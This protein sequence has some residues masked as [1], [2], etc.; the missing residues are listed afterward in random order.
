MN[1]F[2]ERMARIMERSRQILMARKKMRRR[3]AAICV[4]LLI[5]CTAI[6]LFPKNQGAFE[7]E[8]PHNT[9]VGTASNSYVLMFE[10]VDGSTTVT[11]HDMVA[12]FLE[13]LGGI[14]ASFRPDTVPPG[15][16]SVAQEDMATGSSGAKETLTII[17][18]D[19]AGNQKVYT[20]TDNI[21]KCQES[22]QTVSLTKEQIEAI[23][24]YIL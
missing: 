14:Y 15:D 18:T 23:R 7:Q 24:R 9:D 11:D 6:L 21:L 8:Q 16:D 4:P 19:E 3:I 12:E 20:L 13:L 5:S 22:N 2:E 17:I 1:E 10:T